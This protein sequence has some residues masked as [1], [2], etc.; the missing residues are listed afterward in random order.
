MPKTEKQSLA[1]A[2]FRGALWLLL[3]SASARLAGVVG[4][5]ALAHLLVPAQFGV[6]SLVYI[7]TGVAYTLTSFG[8][9]GV[10]LQRFKAIR[11]WE[12]S[13]FWASL[14]LGLAGFVIV[15]LL[16]PVLAVLYHSP[17]IAGLAPILALSMP[18]GALS[19]VPYAKMRSDMNFRF[20]SSYASVEI[21]V[22]QAFTVALAWAGF[23][24][25]SFVIPTPVLAAIKA[26]VFWARTPTRVSFKIRPLQLQFLFGNG[27]AVFGQRLAVELVG[28]GDYAVL[29]LFASHTE[30]GF[31]YFAFRLAAQ[32]VWILAGNFYNVLFPAL[33]Q[34]KAEPERQVE[35]ALRA[36]RLLS[37]AILPICFLQAAAARP[38]LELFFGARWDGS[39]GLTRL[40]SLGIPFDAVAWVA[41]S[42]VVARREFKRGLVYALITLP[43][44]FSMVSAGALLS[45]GF[46][47]AC[48]VALY[49]FILG[50]TYSLA[51]FTRY[52]ANWRA[53]ARLYTRPPLIAGAAVGLAYLLSLTPGVRDFAVLQLAE[54]CLVSGLVYAVL[55]WR[56]EPQ[57]FLEVESRVKKPLMAVVNRVRRIPTVRW[58]EL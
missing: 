34:L 24:V 22:L 44:F 28:Q 12:S 57:V 4:Q 31:Y 14:I 41:A 30:V 46:G 51:V 36:A 10:L 25:M 19:T 32:P 27:L 53:V 55:V 42:L 8:I 2:T 49:Y 39:I 52:G 40:L 15:L 16:S 5:I 20:P 35:A 21:V 48:A 7:I 58:K 23:G 1:G 3:E 29:G 6:I 56:F 45:K 18:L 26:C 43:F 17:Q 50:P 9:D 13:A 54:M 11:L 38:A 37:Y 33:V 47:V